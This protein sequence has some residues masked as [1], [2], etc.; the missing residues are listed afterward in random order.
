M[1]QTKKKRGGFDI[2]VVVSSTFNGRIQAREY[3]SLSVN[4]TGC[5][6]LRAICENLSA[7]A[8]AIIFLMPPETLTIC[9]SA[10][11]SPGSSAS[12]HNACAA[13]SIPIKGR[14]MMPT[15]TSVSF[16]ESACAAVVHGKASRLEATFAGVRPQLCTHMVP[17]A[18]IAKP[19][20]DSGD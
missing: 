13:H 18:P 2:A 10:S 16:R 3:I 6:G 5:V 8:A 19:K 7:R 15:C 4:I 20:T 14:L 12:R 17:E 1:L 9:F 11:H